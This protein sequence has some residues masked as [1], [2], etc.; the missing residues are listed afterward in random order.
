[1][2]RPSSLLSTNQPPRRGR[3]HRHAEAAHTGVLPPTSV[4]A[5]FL[6]CSLC[7]TRDPPLPPTLVAR[8]RTHT[9]RAGHH[10][11][12]ARRRHGGLWTPPGRRC[13]CRDAVRLGSE[14]Q[15]QRL[16]RRRRR[17][18]RPLSLSLAGELDGVQLPEY[19]PGEQGPLACQG[20]ATSL[21]PFDFLRPNPLAP[22]R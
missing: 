18:R 13:R 21:D 15:Q 8:L 16:R 10:E 14:R 20:E 19:P 12:A 9:I 17:S 22:L 4:P 5:L 11:T 3:A 1:M 7:R 6:A 2:T